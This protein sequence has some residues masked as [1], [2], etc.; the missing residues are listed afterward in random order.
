MRN[1]YFMMSGTQLFFRLLLSASV[2]TPGWG[3]I[4]GQVC[5]RN[6]K[7]HFPDWRRAHVEKNQNTLKNYLKILMKK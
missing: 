4:D 2:G 5:V 3:N 6:G 1:K 7:C